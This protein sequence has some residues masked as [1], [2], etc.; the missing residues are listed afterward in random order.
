MFWG[1]Q[2]NLG[3]D[4]SP[5]LINACKELGLPHVGLMAIPFEA[6]LPDIPVDTP[7]IFWGSINWIHQLWESKKWSPGVIFNE[8]FDYRVWNQKWG[9]YCLNSGAVVTTLKEFS[10]SNYKHEDL[11][12]IRPCADDKSFTGEVIEFGL[13]E[14][15]MRN[16][17]GAGLGFEKTQVAVS[18]PVGISAE[19]RLYMLNGH[20]M[21]G[22][23]YRKHGRSF[24]DPNVPKDVL[25]F[26]E[27]M[28]S[29]WTPAPL[30]CLDIAESGDGLY[31]N[32]MGCFHSCGLY[33]ANV[34]KV[35]DEVNRFYD[36]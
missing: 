35:V 33:A 11:F 30:F 7:T 32:E 9:E 23:Y 6:P 21:A 22:S 4:D 26:G 17:M 10:E 29:I 18:E 25:G 28:A 8:N 16:I 5:K 15:W 27:K 1:I 12:F 13:M 2:T 20:V 14:T 34:V 3:K 31:V 36:R 24:R 19:W